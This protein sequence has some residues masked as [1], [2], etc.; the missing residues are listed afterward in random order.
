MFYKSEI[1]TSR[2][3]LQLRWRELYPLP[4]DTADKDLVD[5]TQPGKKFT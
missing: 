5:A 4:E 3:H 1:D 2:V